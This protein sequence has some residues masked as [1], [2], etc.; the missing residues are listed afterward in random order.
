[1]T[2]HVKLADD[3]RRYA[4]FDSRAGEPLGIRMRAA[5]DL[6]DELE[7]ALQLVLEWHGKRGYESPE[8]PDTLLPADE[9]EHEIAE[10]LRLIA[11]MN[12]RRAA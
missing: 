1:M 4:D 8:A 2:K 3:L 11:R 7:K 6:I 9:Q 12:G 10:G 5:A